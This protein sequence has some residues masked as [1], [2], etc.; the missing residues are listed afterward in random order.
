MCIFNAQGRLNL[1]QD[2]NQLRGSAERRRTW[3]VSPHSWLRQGKQC[4]AF[5]WF[6]FM[7]SYQ[8]RP[9]MDWD[10]AKTVERQVGRDH[11]SCSSDHNDD[12]KTEMYFVMLLEYE[13]LGGWRHPWT[14]TKGSVAGGIPEPSPMGSHRGTPTPLFQSLKSWSKKLHTSRLQSLSQSCKGSPVSTFQFLTKVD[15]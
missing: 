9:H 7:P 6:A 13:S 4:T 15:Y 5:M 11:V 14:V 8:R 10:E 3:C 1:V 2:T 12:H